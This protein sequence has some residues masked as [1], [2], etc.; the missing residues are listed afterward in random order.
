MSLNRITA[1]W[2]KS[3]ER[4]KSNDRMICKRCLQDKPESAFSIRTD[5][6]RSNPKFLHKYCKECESELCRQKWEKLRNDPEYI[7]KKKQRTRKWYYKNRERELEKATQRRATEDWKHYSKAYMRIY[8]EINKEAIRPKNNA[9]NRK[10]I[11]RIISEIDNAYIVRLLSHPLV[12]YKVDDVWNDENLILKT[13]VRVATN[14]LKKLLKRIDNE[15][16]N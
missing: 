1:V 16:Q 2:I 11:K 14:R 4:L 7:E 10:Y 3:F 13:K 9:R 15:K 6:R 5:N 8:N 12:G